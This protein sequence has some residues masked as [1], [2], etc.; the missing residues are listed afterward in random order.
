LALAIDDG[1]WV[2]AGDE[3]AIPAIGT[4]LDALPP[5]AQAQVYIE[6]EDERD[7]IDLDTPVAAKMTWLHRGGVAAP[8]ALLHDAVVTATISAGTKVWVACEAKAVR[9]IRRALLGAD[10]VEVGALV[11]RG[12]WRA[13]EE[14]HPDHDYGEDV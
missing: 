8:G 10:R 2:I 13:G 9:G 5:G 14:N 12:Y 4:L 6:V 1:P 11:T 7:E 3:S